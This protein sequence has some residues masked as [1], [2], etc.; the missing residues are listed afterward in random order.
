MHDRFVT[1]QCLNLN[2]M[3]H[4]EKLLMVPFQSR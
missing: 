3:D 4:E 2:E 1:L